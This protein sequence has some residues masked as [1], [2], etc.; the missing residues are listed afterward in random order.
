LISGGSPLQGLEAK[1]VVFLPDVTRIPKK[2][3]DDPK[4]FREELPDWL[5][6]LGRWNRCHLWFVASRCLSQ[7]VVFSV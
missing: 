2:N 3:T 5:K 6:N 7:L 1:I 4:Q